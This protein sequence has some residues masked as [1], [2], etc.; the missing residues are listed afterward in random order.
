M[1]GYI[2]ITENLGGMTLAGKLAPCRGDFKMTA[3]KVQ[4]AL[5]ELSI[6]AGVLLASSTL[7]YYY[8]K[9]DA[10]RAQAE[11]E[12]VA[13]RE[14]K[15]RRRGVLSEQM[16]MEIHRAEQILRSPFWSALGIGIGL[17]AVWLRRLSLILL[18]V[19]FLAVW[20]GLHLL[21]GRA[22]LLE[23]GPVLATLA[24]AL[25]LALLAILVAF[26][27]FLILGWAY[28]MWMAIKHGSFMMF[29][30]CIVGPFALWSFFFFLHRL[31][32]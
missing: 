14:R 15:R 28:W 27:S 6:I 9:F 7:A 30:F 5:L 23:I 19:T 11:T 1:E 4:L 25:V 2:T 31:I 29:F 8:T 17:Y 18:P 22:D 24:L 3:L 10:E 21:R 32:P 26:A 16:A 12:K 20:M 13:E